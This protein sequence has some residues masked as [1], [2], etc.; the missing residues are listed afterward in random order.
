MLRAQLC[1]QMNSTFRGLP[2]AA[3]DVAEQQP[4]D[5]SAAA[6][7]VAAWAFVGGQHAA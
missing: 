5:F 2:L 4:A 6:A 1:V 7:G 3:G